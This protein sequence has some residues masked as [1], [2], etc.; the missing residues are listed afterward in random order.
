MEELELFKKKL[1]NAIAKAYLGGVTIMPFLDE[2]SSFLVKEELKWHSE[3]MAYFDGGIIN[4]DRLRCI[5][6]PNNYNV[7]CNI[8]VFKIEYSKKYYQISHRSILGSL[9][10]LGIKREVLG[11]IVI[12]DDMD[13]YFACQR[14]I[15]EFIKGEFKYIGKAP[16]NL[17]IENEKIEN[18]I[19]YDKK[20][21]FL[22]S[23]RLDTVIAHAF[24]FSRGIALEYIKNG[25][26]FV[27][28]M[29]NQNPSYI[30]KISDIISVRHKGKIKLL[31][32][33]GNTKS[34]RIAV[35]IGKRV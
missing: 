28:Y 1:E 2:A 34:G 31:S 35:N 23:L 10:A 5:I 7:D 21:H 14:E 22:A 16:V 18:V 13:A 19:R 6:A 30:V 12:T 8:V 26:V 11:D 29:V 17:I 32:I 9:M 27:N 24:S 33:D 15:S 4:A 3:I 20:L 25:L